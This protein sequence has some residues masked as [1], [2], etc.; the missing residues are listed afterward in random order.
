MSGIFITGTDTEVGKTVITAGLLITARRCA[1]TAIGMKPVASGAVHTKAGLRNDDAT[2]L[3][4]QS[5]PQLDYATHNPFAFEL[6][7]SPNIAA[8]KADATVSLDI[9]NAAFTRCSAVAD[10]VLVE[11]VGGWRVPLSNTLQTVDLVRNL[12]LPV[13]LV[14]GMRLG[15]INHALLSIEAIKFDGIELLGWIANSI[16]RRYEYHRETM[17]TLLERI[18]APLLGCVEWHDKAVDLERVADAV[19]QGTSRFWT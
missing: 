17:E 16:D 7:A 5:R 9:L 11:G 15:C 4:D 1:K 12:N 8:L 19:G 2:T 13:I 18:D 3:L 10:I 6:P 14:V